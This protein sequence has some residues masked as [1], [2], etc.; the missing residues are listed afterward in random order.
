M[1]LKD[2]NGKT[3]LV[4]GASSG[5]GSDF[6]RHLADAGA[7]LIIT[8]RRE[9]ALAALAEEIKTA[10]PAVRVDVIA[11][12]LGMKDG[13]ETLAAAIEKKGLSV[14]IL[15]NNAGYGSFGAFDEIPWEKENAMLQLDIVTLVKA[16]KIFSAGMKKRGWGR[17]LQI[18]SIAAFQPSPLYA[19]Y[20]A[21]KAFV[22]NYGIA[23]NHE[24]KGTGVSCTVLSPGVTATEFF[25]V[26]E[27]KLTPYQKMAMMKSA[28]VTKIGLTA[29]ARGRTAVVPGFANTAGAVMTR[30]VGR[31]LA[32]AM[33]ASLMK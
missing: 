18:A 22:L 17:I 7:N 8:A 9:D 14:D 26:A 24:M 6:A 29:L 15:I 2:F 1:K 23:V 5:L 31:G 28:D 4:T 3:A 27:Q 32:A 11:Q 10:H 20:G 25:A 19:S 13:V 12:D 33:A 16:T 30:F 21:A